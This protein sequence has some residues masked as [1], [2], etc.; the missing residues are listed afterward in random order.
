MVVSRDQHFNTHT[1]QELWVVGGGKV[2][3]FRG[4][5]NDYKK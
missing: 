4:D 2:N 1:C 5:L 3:K